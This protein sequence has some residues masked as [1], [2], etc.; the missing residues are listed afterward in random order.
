MIDVAS[1]LWLGVGG[2]GA[3]NGKDKIKAEH[4]EHAKLDKVLGA[5]PPE[6]FFSK[7]ML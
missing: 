2:R 1:T 5:C 4:T 3:D 7:L 6:F